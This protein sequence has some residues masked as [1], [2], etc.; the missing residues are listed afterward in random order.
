MTKTC[1]L[2]S[3]HKLS[4][5]QQRSLAAYRVVQVHPPSRYY[6]AADAW[7]LAQNASN[8]HGLDALIVVMPLGM[9][10]D[11]IKLVDGRVPIIRAVLDWR[12]EP[13]RFVRWERVV[14]V[15]TVTHDWTPEGSE[16]QP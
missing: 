13:P 1:V 10:R 12:C 15:V 8:G 4:P 11:F 5:A 3:R 6:S 16:V 2:L 7:V 14:D 9:L